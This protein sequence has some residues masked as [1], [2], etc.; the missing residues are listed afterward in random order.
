M[1]LLVT[2]TVFKS[3]L[4]NL[5]SVPSDE[6]ISLAKQTNQIHGNPCIQSQKINLVNFIK[7]QTIREEKIFW[8]LKNLFLTK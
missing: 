6:L 8:Y 5:V 4:N 1:Y 7:I 2:Y 3:C